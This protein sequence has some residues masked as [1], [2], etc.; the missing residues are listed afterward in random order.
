M[1][2]YAEV[3]EAVKEHCRV[4]VVDASFKLFIEPLELKCNEENTAM[5]ISFFEQ[6]AKQGKAILIST[7][8]LSCLRPSMT[9]YRMEKGVMT[10][11]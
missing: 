5:T 10:K 2:S 7:H 1:N 11:A 8:D 3:F 6:P 9:R 4:A